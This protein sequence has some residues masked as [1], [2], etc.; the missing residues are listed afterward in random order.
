M[1]LLKAVCIFQN[2]VL[3]NYTQQL[4]VRQMAPRLVFYFSKKISF[5]EFFVQKKACAK[6]Q[7][8]MFRIKFHQ[9]LIINEDFELIQHIK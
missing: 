2:D 6:I 7:I 1:N 5:S 4:E 8:E 9:Y 3:L